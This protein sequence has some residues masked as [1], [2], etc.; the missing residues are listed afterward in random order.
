MERGAL[1]YADVG[2]KLSDDAAAAAGSIAISLSLVPLP[3]GGVCAGQLGD[4]ALK[5]HAPSGPMRWKS[6]HSRMRRRREGIRF[7]D[8]ETAFEADST[9]RA[10]K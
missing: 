9:P 3:S 4:L 8:L 7:L 2:M 6:T 10:L 1:A 5:C